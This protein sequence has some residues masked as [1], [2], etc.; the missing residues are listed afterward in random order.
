MID[1]FSFVKVAVLLLYCAFTADVSD[2]LKF[3]ILFLCNNLSRHDG[4]C[5]NLLLGG[6]GLLFRDAG[7]SIC[8]ES[9]D[10]ELP[11]NRMKVT[12]VHEAGACRRGKE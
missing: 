9:T 5:L 8:I 1:P 10:L 2:I 4:L 12:S 6:S 7:P 11:L 3:V